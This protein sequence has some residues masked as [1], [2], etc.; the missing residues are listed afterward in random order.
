L[1]RDAQQVSLARRQKGKP[2][3]KRLAYS[4]TCSLYS[5]S[6]SVTYKPVNDK[7]A[8]L[9]EHVIRN[10]ARALC[11]QAQSKPVLSPLFGDNVERL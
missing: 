9:A 10:V 3:T 5:V 7:G 6:V 4:S 2:L 8:Y 1:E 11:G